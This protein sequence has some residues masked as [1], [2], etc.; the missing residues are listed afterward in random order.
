MGR[1]LTFLAGKLKTVLLFHL[2]SPDLENLPLLFWACFM[3]SLSVFEGPE[4]HWLRVGL[5]QTMLP[6][7]IQTWPQARDVLK[8]YLWTDMLHDVEGEK[9]FHEDLGKHSVVTQLF[10]TE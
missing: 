10:E 4:S 6:L 3:A 7:R 1:N 5:Q 8:R 9:L 2:V